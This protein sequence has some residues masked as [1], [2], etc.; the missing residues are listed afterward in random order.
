MAYVR[1]TKTTE[2]HAVKRDFVKGLSL[3]ED[4]FGNI[5]VGINVETFVEQNPITD[6]GYMNIT[7]KKSKAGNL[8]AE[9]QPDLT[10]GE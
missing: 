5:R 8:Y 10:K 1:K 9:M 7:I 2:E 3:S 6:K 4:K